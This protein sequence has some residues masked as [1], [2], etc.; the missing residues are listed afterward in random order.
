MKFL[1]LGCALLAAS[2]ALAQS[3]PTVLGQVDVAG[4]KVDLVAPTSKGIYENSKTLNLP[5]GRKLA[6]INGML[7]EPFRVNGGWSELTAW[8]KLDFSGAKPLHIKVVVATSA[9][10][11]RDGKGLLASRTGMTNA[12]LADIDKALAQ[13]KALLE[14]AG[15]GKVK[16]EFSVSMENVP[17]FQFLETGK[18][19]AGDPV[20]NG[21][22]LRPIV[23][24]D[25]FATDDNSYWGPFSA[26]V[27][28]HSGIDLWKPLQA[29][30][31]DGIVAYHSA[32]AIGPL[33]PAILAKI[34][35]GERWVPQ[36]T[37]FGQDI[38]SRPDVPHGFSGHSESVR[39]GMIN[40][41]EVLLVQET[42]ADWVKERLAGKSAPYR[43]GDE[44]VFP[45]PGDK[46]SSIATLLGLPDPGTSN[47]AA[48]DPQLP[49]TGDLKVRSVEDAEG[50]R[51]VIDLPKANYTVGTVALPVDVSQSIGK[52][53]VSLSL[54]V[55]TKSHEAWRV[56]LGENTYV[57]TD[58]NTGFGRGGQAVQ[59]V[60]DGNWEQLSLPLPKTS[61]N[62][63]MDHLTGRYE[64][65]LTLA[66]AGRFDTAA[67]TIE[68]ADVSLVVDANK[69][70]LPKTWA[71][72]YEDLRGL[73]ELDSAQTARIVA[74]LAS[75]N[76]T[77]ATQA[78][79]VCSRAKAPGA[80][81]ALLAQA[82]SSN[83][84]LV[85]AACRAIKNLGT[86]ES[87]EALKTVLDVGPF[88]TNRRLALAVIGSDVDK[89]ALKDIQN[90]LVAR[91]W[92]GRLAGVEALAKMTVPNKP[93]QVITMLQDEDPRVRL[94]VVQSAEGDDELSAKRLLYVAVNDPSQLVR[95][96]AFIKL[97]DSKVE[98]VRVEA[99]KAVR[100]ESQSVAVAVL[101]HMAEKPKP[102][103]RPA[104]LQAVVD[105]R[106]MVRFSALMALVS[107]PEPVQVA[108]FQN[109][110]SDDDPMVQ[111]GLIALATQ[112]KVA[113]PADVVA[114]LKA[115]PVPWVAAAA[116]ALGG[117]SQ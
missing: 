111:S 3:E 4:R 97:V 71:D 98:G 67:T 55:R 25:P 50:K 6:W 104:V 92:A 95:Q 77:T 63:L 78:A 51:T 49:K 110:L 116:K 57:L 8:P 52:D 24:T 81:P 35:S 79:W 7:S 12:E 39:R 56:I 99:A 61:A 109:C 85:Y 15:G 17:T 53:N 88:E 83:T 42:V 18:D 72:P 16:V 73:A 65:H 47:A 114:K 59:L 86:P 89:L 91:T 108:E 43:M 102:A 2:L 84:G 54:R 10:A 34:G 117:G 19:T 5:D 75:P 105:P 76:V 60:F 103:N 62:D 107:M 1:T 87:F 101:A 41:T 66:D 112:K 48:Y 64:V 100:N 11:A 113:L 28:I 38:V 40:D 46:T 45:I 37:G 80:L 36:I 30:T 96:S 20:L 70:V 9:F 14:V 31:F 32:K 106:P 94:A 22:A 82:Q 115:S 33:A 27:L 21:S 29:Y 90:L 44:W 26:T 58:A 93:V 13:V 68:V 23:N 69:T 74:D